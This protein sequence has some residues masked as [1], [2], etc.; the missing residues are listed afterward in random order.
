MNPA[1]HVMCRNCGECWPVGGPEPV[2]RMPVG[3][4]C[5]GQGKGHTTT[6]SGAG[7]E[8]YVREATATYTACPVCAERARVRPDGLLAWHQRA[9]PLQPRQRVRRLEKCPGT[10]TA[11]PG[12]G[13]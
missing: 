13:L 4:Q 7:W 10:N 3:I 1:E 5:P 9:L 2:H 6:P 12:W 11:A 8:Q